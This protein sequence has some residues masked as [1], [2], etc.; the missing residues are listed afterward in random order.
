MALGH[1]IAMNSKDRVKEGLRPVPL[2]N[3]F[4]GLGSKTP[5]GLEF[6]VKGRA[7]GRAGGRENM[8]GG[9]AE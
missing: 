9:P 1:G 3:G 5:V 6:G 2:T 4:L 8:G 7:P